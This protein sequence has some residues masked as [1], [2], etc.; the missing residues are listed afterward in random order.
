MH[1]Y[2]LCEGILEAV[3]KRAAGRRVAWVRV[4]A[5]ARHGVDAESMS[6]AF[7]HIAAGTE[8]S[9]ASFDLVA[10]PVR[11]HCRACGHVAETNDLL[12]V[13]PSC[14]RDEVDLTG[15]DE[16]TLESIGYADS[17]AVKSRP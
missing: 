5:G 12:A 16:L 4:R 6:Q 13:C 14:Q 1:E 3:R 17:E 9:G 2:G 11:L 10:I 7:N 8:A 15:G